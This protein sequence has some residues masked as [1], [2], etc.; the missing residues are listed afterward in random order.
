MNVQAD[1]FVITSLL[2]NTAFAAVPVQ[3]EEGTFSFFFF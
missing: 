3:T 1:V 2:L